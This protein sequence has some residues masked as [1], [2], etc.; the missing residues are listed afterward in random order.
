[1]EIQKLDEQFWNERY[2]TQQT[3]WD[4]GFASTPIVEYAQQIQNKNSQILIPGCGNAYEAIFLAKNGFKNITILDI[5]P[6]LIEDLQEKCKNYPQI[7]VLHQDF[8]L[9]H[10]TYDLILEQ[11]FFCAIS[12]SLRANYAQKM[13]QLLKENGKLVGILF[14][15]DFE[16]SPPFG[17][18]GEEYK[19]YF[20]SY[21]TFKTFEP[22]YNSIA[23]R[24]GSEIFMILQKKALG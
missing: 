11:T 5:A 18:S 23:P 19:T 3:G 4:I 1:M 20:Q 7:K 22:C 10:G 24:A 8:F 21:F 6:K 9:H 16:T 2:L 13:H 12:P 14:N 17:G 15:R